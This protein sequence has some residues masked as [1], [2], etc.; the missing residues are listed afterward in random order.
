M[1]DE[2]A[3]LRWRLILGSDANEGFGKDVLSAEDLA[4]DAAL[5]WLYDRPDEDDDVRDLIRNGGSERSRLTA[6]RWINEVH[7]LFPKETVERLEQV[8][9]EERGIHEIVTSKEVLERIEPSE[10]LL[11]A[12]LLTKHLMSPEVRQLARSLVQRVVAELVAQL[13]TEVRHAISGERSRRPSHR[14]SASTFDARRTVA[15]NLA[16]W[17]DEEKRL[18]IRTPH[19]FERRRRRGMQWQV[20]MLVDQSGSMASSVIHSAVTA[21][22]LHGLPS[23][24]SHLI[25]FDT[26][27]VDL[28][29]SVTDPV[30]L[31]LKVQLGGG[32]NIARAVRYAEGLIENPRRTILAVISDF[33]EGGNP[34]ELVRSVER[35]CA[36]G[37]KVLGLAA[38]NREAV[39]VYD[40]ALGKRL[41]SKGAYV[42]AMT[43]LELVDFVVDAL[44]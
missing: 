44:E 43:P 3:L 39:P 5:S 7:R 12:V 29:S 6:P 4:R 2:E 27:V 42:G 31:L 26:D 38:L 13:A 8:A 30:E 37:V 23:V 32:T 21:S 9:V 19:F 16:G 34:D 40:R 28:S 25:V 36:Q 20:I 22:C 24:K 11:R 10:T 33:F 18:Y 14:K 41:A 15:K 17:S 1:S 35:L